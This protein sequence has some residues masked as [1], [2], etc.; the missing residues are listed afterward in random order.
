[1][2]LDISNINVVVYH[3]THIILGQNSNDLFLVTAVDTLTRTSGSTIR[4]YGIIAK[5]VNQAN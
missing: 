1:M 4:H 5:L 2:T 3:V